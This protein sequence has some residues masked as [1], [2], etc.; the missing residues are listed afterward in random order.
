M[1]IIDKQ[2]FIMSV[3]KVFKNEEKVEFI[4]LIFKMI[5]F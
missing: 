5:I 2:P 3:E 4:C 1:H